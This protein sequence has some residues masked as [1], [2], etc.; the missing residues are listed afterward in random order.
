MKKMNKERN[1]SILISS[2][3]IHV[4]VQIYFFHLT[5]T[6]NQNKGFKDSCLVMKTEII[7]SIF[8]FKLR[9]QEA[10]F[11]HHLKQI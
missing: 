2:I 7:N 8:L 1:F 4:L 9:C 6:V 3:L 5:R 10:E 11:S